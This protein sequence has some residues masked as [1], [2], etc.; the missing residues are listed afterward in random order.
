MARSTGG[1]D[2]PRR[3]EGS[4]P[5]PD[6]ATPGP[7]DPTRSTSGESGPAGRQ[8]LLDAAVAVL[9]T[10]GAAALRMTDIAARAGVSFAL[11]A[12][13]FG[14]RDGLVAAAQRVRFEGSVAAD[15]AAIR[16]VVRSAADA[17]E[18]RAGLRAIT[19]AVVDPQRATL[20]LGRTATVGTAHGQPETRELLGGAATTL[21]DELAEV[22]HEA[23]A[24]GLVRADL[25]ARAIATFVQAYALGMVMADLDRERATTG[26]L[27][28]VVA[29]AL[30]ALLVPGADGAT[31]RE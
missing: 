25:D 12:H 7:A 15:V 21:L 20:R 28:A 10:E 17:V 8:R 16:Q 19:A 14:N 30:D 29:A 22:V 5:P 11:I 2:A 3:A 6:G 18:L 4:G 27:A 9:A 24:R 23:Q 31:D 1:Q 26:A 13:H